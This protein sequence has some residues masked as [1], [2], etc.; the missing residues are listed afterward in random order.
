MRIEDIKYR[1]YT[2]SEEMIYNI[3]PVSDRVAIKLPNQEE[4]WAE[5]DYMRCIN[6]KDTIGK[7]IYEGDI[8]EWDDMSNGKYWRVAVVLIDPDIQFVLIKNNRRK[9]SGV[10]GHAFH[11]GRFIYTETE[12]HL[13]VVGNVWEGYKDLSGNIHFIDCF[14]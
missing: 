13:T 14:K 2:D 6:K 3:M 11:Y 5:F 9:P 8:V 4:I 12:K 7:D 10:I 1:A